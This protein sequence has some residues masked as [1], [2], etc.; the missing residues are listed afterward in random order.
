MA[1]NRHGV[2]VLL[3][4]SYRTVFIGPAVQTSERGNFRFSP[5]IIIVSYFYCPTNAL[6]YRYL[7]IKNL[8]CI[9]V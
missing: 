3:K 2:Q 9:K 7:E 4:S 8:R 5:C 6:S 1:L